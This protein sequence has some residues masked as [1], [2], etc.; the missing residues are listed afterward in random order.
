LLDVFRYSVRVAAD[1]ESGVCVYTRKSRFDVAAPLTF[2]EQYPALTA[3]D[4]LLGAIAG[5]LVTGFRQLARRQRLAIDR[6]EALLQADLHNPLAC[7]G[8]VGAEGEPRF[9]AIRMTLFV[10]TL[11]DP[12]RMRALWDEVLRRSPLW[13]TLRSCVRLELRLEFT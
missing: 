4:Y 8:A 6:L 13:N 12:D 2:D 11:E 1:S 7:L 10:D 5:E 9:E 3:G